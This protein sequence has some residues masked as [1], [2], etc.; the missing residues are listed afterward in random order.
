MLALVLL[1]APHQNIDHAAGFR[2]LN[3]SFEGE[4][5]YLDKA[6]DGK[7]KSFPISLRLTAYADGAT[8][9]TKYRF[10]PGRYQ[11]SVRV[12]SV[13][14]DGTAWTERFADG[15][16]ED[17]ALTNWAEFCANRADWFEIERTRLTATGT[18]KVRFRMTI[19]DKEFRSNKSL[20]M[21][22][23]AAW[24]FSHE[25]ILPRVRG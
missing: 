8:F 4:M 14:P 11:L 21:P 22:K 24:E 2:R 12:V 3:G 9:A 6:G 13:S 17:F 1:L 25:M 23:A 19:G 16:R 10:A 7:T 5:R 15:S 18:D 20:L